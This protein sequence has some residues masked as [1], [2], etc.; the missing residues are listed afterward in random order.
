MNYR[1]KVIPYKGV[2][3]KGGTQGVSQ[4]LENI[5]NE[6]ADLNWEFQELATIDIVVPPGCLGK[7]LGMGNTS[8][9]MD[10]LIFKTPK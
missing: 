7:L 2:Q 5:I 9:G 3:G 6:M 4:D 8:Y 1:Y 10:Q